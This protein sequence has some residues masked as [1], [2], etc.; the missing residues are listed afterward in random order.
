MESLHEDTSNVLGLG[1]GM[2]SSL[3]LFRFYDYFIQCFLFYSILSIV[4]DVF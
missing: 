3:S 4:I 2:F 1:G